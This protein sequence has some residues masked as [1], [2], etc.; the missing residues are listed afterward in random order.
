MKANLVYTESL[1]RCT[2]IQIEH[3]IGTR[4]IEMVIC[5]L[6]DFEEEKTFKASDIE[7]AIRNE[8]R[9]CGIHRISDWE[10][11]DYFPDIIKERAK[12]IAQQLFPD[13]YE[14]YTEPIK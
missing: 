7:K 8:L 6:L 5:D 3:I 9:I 1:K 2:R 10:D 4:E 11:S 13:F 12:K 14:P